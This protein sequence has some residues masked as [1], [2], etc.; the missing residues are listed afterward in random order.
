LLLRDCGDPAGTVEDDEASAGGA[1]IDSAEIVGHGGFLSESDCARLCS[2]GGCLARKAG[3][4]QKAIDV[5]DVGVDGG[6][7]LLWRPAELNA[8]NRTH[9]GSSFSR[10]TPGVELNTETTGENVFD[11]CGK[12]FTN[13]VDDFGT[14]HRVIGDDTLSEGWIGFGKIQ[15]G[16]G[17]RTE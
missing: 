10:G 9:D 3:E 13:G 2:G 1:L 5:G 17:T 16:S 4:V 12:L 11:G 14:H 7:G 6:L 8:E 15:N